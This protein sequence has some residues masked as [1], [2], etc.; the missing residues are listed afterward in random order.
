MMVEVYEYAFM[1]AGSAKQPCKPAIP[2]AG[3]TKA[4]PAVDSTV[5]AQPL[6]HVSDELPGEP[7]ISARFS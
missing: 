4:A 1:V 2:S 3:G 5:L 6:P 7:T